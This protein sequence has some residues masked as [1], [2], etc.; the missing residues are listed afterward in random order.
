MTTTLQRLPFTEGDFVEFRANNYSGTGRVCGLIPLS[1]FENYG[2][3]IHYETLELQQAT[4]FAHYSCLVVPLYDGHVLE[5]CVKIVR[6][7]Q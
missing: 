5:P 2:V 3:V 4:P 6:G 7:S 1:G